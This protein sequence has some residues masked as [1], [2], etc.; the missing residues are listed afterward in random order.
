MI[1][2]PRPGWPKLKQALEATSSDQKW[3]LSADFV[4]RCVVLLVGCARAKLVRQCST[5]S[6][7][8]ACLCK[9]FRQPREAGSCMV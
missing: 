7:S 6:I 9:L 8:A 5:S 2:R 3:V 4:M 1:F